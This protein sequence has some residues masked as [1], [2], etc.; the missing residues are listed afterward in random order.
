MKIIL[1]IILLSL[2]LS[3]LADDKYGELIFEDKFERKESQET[4]DEPG[5]GWLTNS[6]RRAKGN[7]QTDLRDG[8]IYVFRHKEADHAASLKREI[9]FQNGTIG[10]K[11]KFADKKDNI[12]L[13]LADPQEKSVHAGHLFHI[14]IKPDRVILVDL[15]TGQMDLK[16]RPAYQN[17]TLTEE[18][19]KL[20]A[21]KQ[22]AFRNKL[23]LDKWHQVYATINGD[24][25]SV[26][27]NGKAVASF[28]SPGFSHPIKRNL[29]FLVGKGVSIDDVQV[30]KKD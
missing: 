30:W 14:T 20:M 9:E 29:R 25:I 18:Q 16:I 11:L 1:L 27:I 21:S 6:K 15:K 19:K 4:K 8:H 7:K 17:K 2:S 5:N 22:K 3:V 23:A 10:I 13:N 28:K 12:Y 24:E 26:E